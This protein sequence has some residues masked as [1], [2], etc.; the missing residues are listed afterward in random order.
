MYR[1]RAYGIGIHSE[2]D[3]E[4]PQSADV[5]A[6]VT[7][8]Y[9]A[10]DRAAL[11]FKANGAALHVLPDEIVIAWSLFGAFALRG[12]TEIVIDPAAGADEGLIRN[13]L[14][15]SVM[16]LLLHQRGLFVVHAS[17]VCI[18]G[19]AVAF[20]AES[21]MGKSTTA[22][23]LYTRGHRFIAD[24]VL[25]LQ[26]DVEGRLMALPGFPRFKL[27]SQAASAIGYDAAGMPAISKHHDKLLQSA[28]ER[29]VDAPLPLSRLYMLADGEI[30][31]QPLESRAAL[32]EVMRHAYVGHLALLHGVD[33]PRMA[34]DA[35]AHFRRCEQVTRLGLMRTLSRPRD[36]AQLEVVS[37]M[38]EADARS[39]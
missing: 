11:A 35:A 39:D 38:I 12:G 26:L 25:A 33:V 24:D 10:V 31:V 20:A 9:G 1:Y 13:A 27:W 30:G 29:S 37:Q 5:T 14:L 19:Q 2:I 22:V 36:L 32:I 17:A 23:A 16:A 8:R 4:S 21:G 18:D 3:L 6:D 15:A 34:G 7:I 28:V